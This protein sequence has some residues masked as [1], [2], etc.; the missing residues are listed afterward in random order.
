MNQLAQINDRDAEISQELFEIEQGERPMEK[1]L[2]EHDEMF[3]HE[4][5]L[6]AEREEIRDERERV[7]N[8]VTV[9]GA[10]HYDD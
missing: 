5:W 4:E 1:Y 10:A 2:F 9:S 8:I 7:L 6:E 3:N